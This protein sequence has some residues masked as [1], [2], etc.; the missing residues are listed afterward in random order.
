M[1]RFISVFLICMITNC[2][3]AQT[4]RIQG[5][6]L[7]EHNELISSAA[8]QCYGEN[9]SFLGG[10]ISGT[11]GKFIIKQ[12]VSNQQCKLLITYIGY[13]SYEMN[14]QL[15]DDVNVGDIILKSA[16]QLLDEVAVTAN[17][18][19]RKDNKLMVFPSK[20]QKHHAY[21]G[22]S[23]LS[24]LMIPNLNVDPFNKTVST[25]Q[26]N[27]LLCI[28]GREASMDEIKTLDPKD[29]LR[30]DFYESHHPEHPAA[31]SVIDYI[32]TVHNYGATIVGNLNQ[33][34]N[35]VKGNGGVS[36]KVYHKKS[37]FSFYVNGNYDHYTPDRG[38]ETDIRFGFP[39]EVVVRTTRTLPSPIHG[40]TFNTTLSYLFQ[41]ANNQLA[42]SAKL[43]KG[44]SK[45][46]HKKTELYNNHSVDES[47]TEKTRS[48]D[49]LSAFQIS[50]NR[51]MKHMQIL[52]VKL[53]GSYNKNAYNR[54]Y[55]SLNVS[56]ANSFLSDTR[57]HFYYLNPTLLYVKTIKQH[58]VFLD[59]NYSRKQTDNTY[60]YQDQATKSKLKDEQTNIM[61]GYNV[62]IKK[63]AS[64]TL[65]WADKLVAIDNGE[66]SLFKH[67][68]APSTFLNLYLPKQN[69]VNIQFG[70]GIFDPEMR[71]QNNTEQIIDR[72]QILKGNPNLKT[73]YSWDASLTYTK[74][75]QWGALSYFFKYRQDGKR[76]YEQVD[77]DPERELFV[78]NYL[79]GGNHIQII[80]DVE[81]QFKLI[82]D[83]L[84]WMVTAEYG[85]DTEYDWRKIRK[86]NFIV[87]TKFLFTHK[88]MMASAELTTPVSYV[89]RGSVFTVPVSLKINVG[90]TLNCWHFEAG[91]QNPF[92]CAIKSE[93]YNDRYSKV[94]CNY[95]P[96]VLNHIFYININ[97]RFNMGKK[98]Q[99]KEVEMENGK[100]SGILKVNDSLNGK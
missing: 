100:H 90:Y 85:C 66:N 32:L 27:T 35:Y 82:P 67:Y 80:S 16:S 31:T 48:E 38:E 4:I 42:I 10:T 62:R 55:Q 60:Y 81:A 45:N 73:S 65:Q 61:A 29:I 43:E 74:G 23:A 44:N 33:R 52:R 30:V 91:T 96:G 47:V 3:H 12:A 53:F 15:A 46:N 88:N 14:L 59:I 11:D 94:T 19:V 86:E 97:Y 56:S 28:N 77:Y 6:I 99:F 72:Y 5:R 79:N 25:R 64:I 49:A 7:D 50:Y 63:V 57:E 21:D 26:G 24:V 34:L 84:K 36:A 83:K 18:A 2:I 76:I 20:S 92:S 93:Y 98:H 87:Q 68:F 1:L 75:F 22:Y 70:S 17:Q 71:Y 58:S 54:F 13:Q 39:D 40:N 41:D 89:A 51:R 37:E 8:I 78:H 69:T 95:Q 9:K